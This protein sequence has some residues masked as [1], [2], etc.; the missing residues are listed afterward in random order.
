MIQ[1]ITKYTALAV[2]LSVFSFLGADQAQAQRACGTMEYLEQQI[3]NDPDRGIRLQQV[4]EQADAYAL[5]H[6]SDLQRDLVM[7]PVVV[8]VVWNTTSENVSDARILAQID[9]L[10]ADFSRTNSDADQ[11]PGAFLG[12]AMNTDVQFCLAQRDP[13]GNATTG[14]VRTQTTKS[15]F[16][17]NDNVKKANMGGSDA[18]PRDSYL[19]LWVC[20]L[21]SGLLGY[22]QFPDGPSNTDGV[23]VDYGT[24]GSLT[25]PGTLSPYQY[26]R[27]ATH[28]IG[29]WLNLRHIWGDDGTGCSG[30]D[31]VSDTPN[32]GGSNGGCPNFPHVSCSNGPNGDMFMNY[33]DY[34]NDAC[35][36]LFTQGQTTRMQSLFGSGGSRTSILNSMGCVAP[37]GGT[38]CGVPTGLNTTAITNG[39]A[40]LTWAN[41]AG[42]ISYDVRFRPVGSGTWSTAQV[43]SN[44]APLVG[45]ESDLTYEW[46][47]RTNCSSATSDYSSTVTFATTG[48]STTCS[49]PYEANN[50]KGQATT[51]TVNTDIHA[52]IGVKKDRD[53]FKFQ[54]TSSDRNIQIDLTDLPHDYDVRLYR[55]SSLVGSSLSGGTTAEQIVYNTS[56]VSTY[57]IKVTAYGGVFDASACYQLRASISSNSFREGA[58]DAIGTAKEQMDGVLNLYPNPV[59][60]DMDIVYATDATGVIQISIIDAMG[61]LVSME[62]RSVQDGNNDLHFTLPTLVNGIYLMRITEGD[63]TSQRR[64]MITH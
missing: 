47:V 59:D 32:Q 19:N 44:S 12:L 46:S 61:R 3:A 37:G 38:G 5:E 4:D 64:F 35:M 2:G 48:G 41:V 28:E 27:S 10:N 15:S 39:S 29:H 45:L 62:Q 55:G 1:N 51:I 26:G 23:V 50:S 43:S 40:T 16:S 52:Q 18:W 60:H 14:I 13:D 31:Q 54:N 21:G 30:S 8:H 36:N 25:T 34:S 9:Q 57:Y 11:T 58:P 22:A 17:S 7:I 42:A 49:D 56:T 63:R 53:W 33:M 20:D 24:V 6:G